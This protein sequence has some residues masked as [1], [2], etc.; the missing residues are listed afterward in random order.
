MTHILFLRFFDTVKRINFTYQFTEMCK[1]ELQLTKTL[2]EFTDKVIEERK[3]FR[4]ETQTNLKEVKRKLAFLDL[5]LQAKADG[6]PLDDEG[7][8]EEVDTFMFEG[9]DTTTSGIS[10]ALL[11][12][13]RHPD[14]QQ[15][16]YEECRDVLGEK[17][18]LTMQDLNQLSYLEMFI[19]ESMRLHPPVI[20]FPLNLIK[21]LKRFFFVKMSEKRFG[22]VVTDFSSVF[23]A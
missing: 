15:Q 20:E 13:A 9:H 1:R 23:F 6:K 19:K 3:S 16:V 10:F 7:I 5:L 2:H 11:N 21:V 4:N 17:K 22:L 8:R 18:S 12:L 14:L